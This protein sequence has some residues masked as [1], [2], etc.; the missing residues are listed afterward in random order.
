[1]TDDPKDKFKYL[2]KSRHRFRKSLST[3]NI[4][5][6]TPHRVLQ[7][8][9][10]NV[11]ESIFAIDTE[12]SSMVDIFSVLPEKGN[13]VEGMVY[14]PRK[15]FSPRWKIY[16]P[17]NLQSKTNIMSQDHRKYVYLKRRSLSC[18]LNPLSL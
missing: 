7:D 11:G 3:N 12:K 5:S 8:T 6:D 18:W 2:S 13:P 15:Y 17:R 4:L 1:M 14:D 16:S 9:P 10:N